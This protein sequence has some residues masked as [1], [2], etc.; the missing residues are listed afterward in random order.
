MRI[1]AKG[2][3]AIKA[4]VDLSLNYD[5]GLIPIYRIAERQGIPQRYLEQVLLLLKRSGFLI[6]RRGVSGGYHLVKP[7]SE[8]SL[9]E[10]IRAV[11][12]SPAPFEFGRRSGRAQTDD[13]LAE[14]WKEI[15]EA[16]EKVIARVTFADLA[17]RA[18]E[19]KSAAR[20]M[21]HI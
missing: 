13:D 19:R 20:P 8:I 9:G 14:L 10:V 7:P 1:S 18:E 16:V 15:S 5:K 21:Y 11:E 3:Y 2:E 17:K 6:S 12:G 4:L